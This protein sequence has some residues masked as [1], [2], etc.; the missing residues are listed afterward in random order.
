MDI[1]EWLR[2]GEELLWTGKPLC[3]KTLDQTYKG[4]FL[5][6]LLIGGGLTIILEALYIRAALMS[7]VGIKPVMIILLPIL[8]L[9]SAASILIGGRKIRLLTY[10]A[11][12]RR[13]MV[14]SDSMAE[15]PYKRIKEAVFKMDADGHETLL[16]GSEAVK[17]RPVKWR[18][19]SLYAKNDASDD[20]NKPCEKYALYA[21]SD[22]DGLRAVM[23]EKTGL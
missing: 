20:M 21:V 18:D 9:Y 13:L 11:T 8:C 17:S 14:V 5:R 19:L 2:D 16:C 4:A 23:K 6:R 3:E 10:A 7:E 12:D 1:K 15:M 22:P